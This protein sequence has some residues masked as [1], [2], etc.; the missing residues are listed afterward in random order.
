MA[1]ASIRGNLTVSPAATLIPQV[2][3]ALI[4]LLFLVSGLLKIGKFAGVAGLLAAS[5]AW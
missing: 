1:E 3:R 5:V 2:G 4:G